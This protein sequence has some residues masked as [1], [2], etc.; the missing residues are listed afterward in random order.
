LRESLRSGTIETNDP[1]RVV[2]T[3]VQEKAVAHPTDARFTHRA[4]EKLLDLPNARVS[5]C[6]RTI[7]GW[8][9]AP[10]SWT[11]AIRTRISSSAPGGNGSSCTRGS[12]GSSATFRR[13][14]EGATQRSKTAWA[15]NSISRGVCAI[16]S[17]VSAG[18]R[19]IRCTPQ[20]EYIGRGKARA[21]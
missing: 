3:T 16:K 5:D 14:F 20:V 11:G 18:R 6:A 10:P 2:D 12:A 4:I 15:R 21:P 8:P 7:G 19:S 9:S 1:E 13:K 17:R